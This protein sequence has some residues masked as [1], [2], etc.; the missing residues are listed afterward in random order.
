MFLLESFLV[1]LH[2]FMF[3]YPYKKD[4][5]LP[6]FIDIYRATGYAH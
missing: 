5:A 1:V 3:Q 6:K 4:L 2:A